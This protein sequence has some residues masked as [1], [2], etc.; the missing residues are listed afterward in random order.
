MVGS[1]AYRKGVAPLRVGEGRVYPAGPPTEA[2]FCWR[3]FLPSP[4]NGRCE[5]RVMADSLHTA[6]LGWS[7]NH[8]RKRSLGIA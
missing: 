7:S 6:D 5:A 3:Q 4:T 1:T 8:G 2:F